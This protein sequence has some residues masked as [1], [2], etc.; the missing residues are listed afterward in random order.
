M[1]F[2]M[3]LLQILNLSEFRL[4]ESRLCKSIIAEGGGRSFVKV[5]FEGTN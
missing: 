3:L 1:T 2:K 4:F 5:M